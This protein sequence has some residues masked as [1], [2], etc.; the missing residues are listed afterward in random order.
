MG[1]F[2]SRMEET[3]ERISE[4][5][6]RTTEITQLNKEN[7]LRKIKRAPGTCGTKAG[8]ICVI[9]V[10]EEVRKRVRLKKFSKL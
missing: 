7:R 2:N 6:S 1:E 8:D 3:E 10:L 5:K 4:L 9:G